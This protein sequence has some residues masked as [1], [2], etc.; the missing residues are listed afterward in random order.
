RNTLQRK[1]LTEAFNFHYKNNEIYKSFCVKK[2]IGL[3]DVERDCRCIPLIPSTV[4]KSMNIRTATGEHTVKRCISSGTQGS[5]SVIERDNTTL[6]RFLGSVRNTLDNVYGIEDAII[7]NLG[8]SADE[9]KDVWFSYVMSV[10][11]MI[12][13]TIDYVVNGQF[14][15]DKAAGDIKKFSLDYKDVFIIGAPVM[16]VELY[17]YMKKNGFRVANGEKVFVITA[18]G[19]KKH[20]GKSITR[21]EFDN[22]CVEMFD[23]I[24]KS[25]I[26]DVFNMVELNTIIPEC[27]S[28]SKHVPVWLDAFTI[29]LDT[30]EINKKG[31]EGLLA[32]LDAGAASYPGFVMSGDLGRISYIDDCPCGRNGICV[33][34]TRRINT[35]ESRGC[36]LKIEKNLKNNIQSR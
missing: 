33:E 11:D 5:V 15:A 23:G 18:G 34:I 29:N 10:S 13:P 22:I 24:K 9:A 26:R 3:S 14:L 32:F 35:I 21:P 2:E 8:P 20:E 6:E 19:W 28:G 16:F 1:L 17:E 30:F 12:F 25:R 36:A 4:F 7:K 31:E 27:G